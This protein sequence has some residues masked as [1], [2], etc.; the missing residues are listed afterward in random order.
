MS[1]SVELL[2]LQARLSHGKEGSLTSQTLIRGGESL[3]KF[4]SG[5][6]IALLSSRA[7]N[8]VGMNIVGRL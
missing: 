6:C 8:K 2:V 4:S 7:P 1:G 5:F 3:V